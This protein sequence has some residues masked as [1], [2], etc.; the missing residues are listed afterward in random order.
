MASGVIAS[1]LALSL[2]KLVVVDVAIIVDIILLQYG[3]N[4]VA[5]LLITDVNT[6]C[7]GRKSL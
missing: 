4:Q 6:L 5:Q 3:V 1:V 7:I 2:Y